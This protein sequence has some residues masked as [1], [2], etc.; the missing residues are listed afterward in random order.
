M[1]VVKL[2][3][4]G[5]KREVLEKKRSLRGRRERIMEDRTWKERKMKW[6]IEEIARKEERKG[7]R[8]WVGYGRIKIDE[9]WWSWDEEE[10]ILKDGRGNIR[11]EKQGEGRGERIEGIK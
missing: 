11:G 1:I 2:G 4:E 9:Q 7:R 6:K 5:Q 8:V 10:E 3:N